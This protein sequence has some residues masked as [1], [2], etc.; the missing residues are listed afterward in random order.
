[1]TVHVRRPRTLLQQARLAQWTTVGWMVIE[2]VVAI[3]AGIAARSVALTAFEVDSGIELAEPGGHRRTREDLTSVVFL[4]P[5]RRRRKVRL[6]PR[7]RRLATQVTLGRRRRNR[8]LP[9]DMTSEVIRRLS[10][11]DA[12]ILKSPAS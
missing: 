2:G 6:V 1:M 7:R 4:E 8:C 10:G 9:G 5:F 12:H 11:V 3:G